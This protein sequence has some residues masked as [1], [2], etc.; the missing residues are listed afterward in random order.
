MKIKIMTT[1]KTIFVLTTVLFFG[2]CFNFFNFNFEPK[3]ILAESFTCDSGNLSET[4]Y[5]N[6][7]HNI[8]GE[9]I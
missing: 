9:I 1:T 5:V 2:L 7:F 4:C 3:I 6:T 8:T